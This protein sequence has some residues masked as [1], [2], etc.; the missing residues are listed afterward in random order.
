[1]IDP[2]TL[3]VVQAGLQQ[4]CDEMDLTFSRAA[5][6]PVI[7]EADDRSDGIYSATDGSL[8]AQGSK[9]LPVFVGVM[10]FSTRTL[11]KRIQA[12][13]TAAPDPGDI[14]IVNDPYLGG[15][16]LMDVRFAMPVWREGRIWCWLSNTGH[17]PDT[18]GMVPGGFS[19][20]AI[21]AEQEGLRLPPV[22]LFKRG[23]LDQEIWSIIQSNI[24]V[25]DQRIGDVKAQASAL[26][27]GADRLG[28]LLD[29]YGDA[30]VAEA[31]ALMRDLAARQMR[32]M[33]GLIPEGSYHAR[34]YVD[35]DG[36]VN[37][38]L[39]IAL[40][41][42]R[43]ATGLVFDFAGSSP[44]CMGPMNSVRATTLS[45]VY[46]AMRHIFPDV[47][48]SA[49]AFDPLEVV[50]IDGTFLDAQ[51]PRPVSGCAA[52]V[53]QRIAEAVFAALV[54]AIPD[55]VT[56]SP[57]G[58]S[59]NFGLGGTDPDSGA[60]YVMYQI[61]GGGYGG[62]AGG[63]GISNGCSTI[64][65]SR[66]PPV[67]IMEQKYPVLYRR[68][69]LHEGSGGAGEYRGGFGLDY[70]IEL[71]RGEARA[72]F[73]MDHGRVGPQGALGGG[74]GA[75][76]RVEVH[77]GGTV[78]VPEHLSKAQDIVL[79]PGDRVRVRTPGGGGYG[80]PVERDPAA[81]AE[82]VRLGRYSVEEAAALW[83]GR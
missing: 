64:G 11:V 79:T 13:V 26:M 78:M 80:D 9:G 17:W 5:F 22:K 72:S 61:S 50:G 19:A 4:V 66:A 71:L 58:T 31:I 30:V 6:S 34:A 40:T 29:R 25:A 83:P 10:Q 57:A 82:D 54:Q 8:I 47:P 65:I 36:V 53:S 67:E 51:Y 20:T 28:Q 24:R 43:S 49:G 35:S 1:M 32:A 39:T 76:N 27:V 46:L 68:Y 41:V 63:D 77:R 81:V 62:F 42:A 59:G 69:A 44:P 16:H 12:G 70:E 15:T 52:E 23:V 14:Y 33:I 21:S 7:A 48:M 60:G 73:V 55:R 56:A 45:S 74:D 38:P 2:V 75:V 37:Q 18:G 3:A